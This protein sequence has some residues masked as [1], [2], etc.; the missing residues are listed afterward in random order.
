MQT[1]DIMRHM[2]GEVDEMAPAQGPTSLPKGVIGIQNMG[3]TCY[4]NSAIQALRAYPEMTVLCTQRILEKECADQT[5]NPYRILSAF[6][7]LVQSLTSGQGGFVRPTGF[8][9]SMS[10]VV[11]GTIYEEFVRRSPQ[12]AHEYVVWLLDQLYMASARSVELTTEKVVGDAMNAWKTAFEKSWSPLTSLFFGLLRVHYRCSACETVHA[13]YETFNTLK[14]QLHD[15]LDWSECIEQEIMGEEVIDGYACETCE[16]AGRPRAP[17]LKT[18]RLWKLPKLLILTVKRYG[19]YGERVNLPVVHDN[20][21]LKFTEL[22]A[23]ESG[24]YSKQKWYNTVA[25][26][27]HLGRGLGGGHYVCQARS[28][29]WKKWYLYDDETAHEISAP[30]Y[31]RHTFMVFMRATED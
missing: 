31:G 18:A 28:A 9:E 6:S 27:D 26:V 3:N 29:P 17:A 25:V 10:S 15:G 19:N 7:D 21:E 13:R 14:I 11:T 30:S 2:S 22:F 8:F 16:K 1:S 4:L 12:D 24:H 23:E 20:S 5:T